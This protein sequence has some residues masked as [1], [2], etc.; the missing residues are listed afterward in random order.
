MRIT[1]ELLHPDAENDGTFVHAWAEVLAF[2]GQRNLAAGAAVKSF[3]GALPP[4]PWHWNSA[5]L[6]DG[7]TP[8]GLP[9]IPAAEHRN[10]GWLSEGRNNAHQAAAMTVD[11]GESMMVDAVRLLPAKR[12]TSDLPS[13]FGFPRKLTIALAATDE[14]ALPGRWAVVAECELPNPGHNPVRIPITASRGR[15][16]RIEAT[17]LWKAFESYP[18]FFALSEVEVLAEEKN[19]ALGKA[20]RSPDGMMNIIAAGGRFWSSAALERWLRT[21]RPPGSDPRVAGP[22]GPALVA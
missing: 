21:G 11:L 2:A 22:A 8:L 7:Q 18:A 5:F 13:G 10:I 17:E 19:L 12:P 4:A 20:V 6:V 1:A 9:E 3:G 14:P 15:Y 16:V